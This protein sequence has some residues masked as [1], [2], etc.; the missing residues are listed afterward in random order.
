MNSTYRETFSR[1]KALFLAPVVV[2][3]V[4]ALWFALGTPKQYKAGATL[5]VDTQSGPSSLDESNPGLLTPSAR[6]QQLLAELLVTKRFLAEIGSRGPLDDY[7][8][9]NPSEGW[10]PTSLLRRL[11]GGSS[12][13]D[14]RA[15]ALDFKHIVTLVPGGQVLSI[16]LRGPTPAVAVGTLQALITS[17]NLQR[18]ELDVSR[19][20]DSMTTFTNR[21]SAAKTT[22]SRL[23]K[24]MNDG[25]LSASEIQGLAPVRRTAQAQLRNATRGYNQAALALDA[26][27]KETGLYQEIDKPTLPA[28]A[29]S[30]MKK[31]VLTVFGG[32][33]VG[34]LLS[35]LAL[36]LFTGTKSQPEAELRN[37]VSMSERD[38]DDLGGTRASN[39]AGD[40]SEHRVAPTEHEHSR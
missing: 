30:G 23:N 36:V 4:L 31:S 33:F 26:A 8:A 37:V 40:G 15:Q 25:T 10:A 27:K 19:Q 20:Q 21:I 2:T 7:L 28:P 17:F 38:L 34:A 5:F 11:R 24:E 1:H 14:R 35:F 9:K 12:V 32:L 3:T 6:A 22:L 39:G 18:R 16:E 29:V 13:G